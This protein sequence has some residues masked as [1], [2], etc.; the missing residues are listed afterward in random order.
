MDRTGGVLDAGNDV[1]GCLAAV[2]ELG[3][4]SLLTLDRPVL[5]AEVRRVGEQAKQERYR[6]SAF[7]S[8]LDLPPDSER[9]RRDVAVEAASLP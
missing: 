7:G 5:T 2:H 6:Y 1:E 8:F 3:L 9:G 4:A